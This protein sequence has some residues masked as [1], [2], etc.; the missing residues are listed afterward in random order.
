M[1]LPLVLKRTLGSQRLLC[2]FARDRR[3]IAAI[4]F[5]YLVPIILIMLVGTVEL[6]RA[7][8]MDRRFGQVTSMV[9]DLVAREE[10]MSAADVRAIY[11]IVDKVMSPFD[12]STLTV[13]I[14]PVKASPTNATNTRVYPATTNRPS[15]PAS[16][17]QLAKCSTYALTDGLVAKGASVIVVET[18]YVFTPLYVKYILDGA[19]WH[20][21]AYASPRN[22]CVDFDGDNCVSSCF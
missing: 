13:S 17:A 19:T 2:N 16:G 10:K 11:N 4:E 18:S 20:D 6:S 7:V 15:L 8:S 22:S 14:I 1:E 9:A 5:G 3:G 21:K 12:A